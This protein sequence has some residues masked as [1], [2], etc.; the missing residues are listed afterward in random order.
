MQM[1]FSAGKRGI[2]SNK[3]G[4]REN[5]EKEGS[6]GWTT[7]S[8]VVGRTRDERDWDHCGL[9]IALLLRLQ[10]GKLRVVLGGG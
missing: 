10:G 4:W 3:V 9:R 2:S 1:D 6:G 7:V 8:G 5:R